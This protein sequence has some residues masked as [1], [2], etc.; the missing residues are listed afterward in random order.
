MPQ[1]YNYIPIPNQ[2]NQSAQLI[3]TCGADEEELDYYP[4]VARRRSLL[5][6]I[7]IEYDPNINEFFSHLDRATIMNSEGFMKAPEAL[8]ITDEYSCEIVQRYLPLIEEHQYEFDI[9]TGEPIIENE[10]VSAQSTV[11]RRV[12]KN[13]RDKR[14]LSLA[15][16][17]LDSIEKNLTILNDDK[18]DIAQ[19]IDAL[20]LSINGRFDSLKS[21]IDL[22]FE[23]Q[24]DRFIVALRDLKTDQNEVNKSEKASSENSANIRFEN[25]DKRLMEVKSETK[26]FK[27]AL[28]TIAATIA[29]A[30]IAPYTQTLV[31]LLGY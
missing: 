17:K 25:L 12:M 10:A 24:F 11:E 2:N 30:L 7:D 31:K 29:A 20:S 27:Y 16:S 3:T 1:S 22:K 8:F 13:E 14:E 23:R 28:Y 15:I 9:S 19:K 5:E 4:E 18:R 6:D 26:A 21:D